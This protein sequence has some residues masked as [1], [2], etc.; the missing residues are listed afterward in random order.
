MSPATV[1]LPD[2]VVTV[3][4]EMA[5]YPGNYGLTGRRD[6]RTEFTAKFVGKS[7]K[8]MPQIDGRE[9]PLG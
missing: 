6:E 8:N 7:V 5:I 1:S 3:G 2:E 9:G 4:T